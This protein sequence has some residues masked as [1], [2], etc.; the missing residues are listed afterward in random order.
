[1][2][3]RVAHIHKVGGSIPSPAPS[4]GFVSSSLTVTIRSLNYWACLVLILVQQVSAGE[5]VS[6]P[7]Q[8]DKQ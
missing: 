1:M 5:P 8:Y 4:V 6:C 3:A 2:V 7:V